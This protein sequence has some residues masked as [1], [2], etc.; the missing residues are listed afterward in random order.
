M[1][2]LNHESDRLDRSRGGNQV[3]VINVDNEFIE[4]IWQDNIALGDSIQII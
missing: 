4:S 3:Y 1:K 2:K